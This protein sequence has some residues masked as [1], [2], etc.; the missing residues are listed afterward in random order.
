M[1]D[2]IDGN[3]GR[4]HGVLAVDMR[5]VGKSFGASPILR[6]F[7]LAIERGSFVALLGASGS[8]KST[9]LR[10]LL[11]LEDIDSG[12]V[13]VAPNRTV[14]FQDARLVR[15][16]DVSAN[17]LIGQKRTAAARQVAVRALHE[18]GLSHRLH[19]WPH[20]LSGGEAQR[21]ALARALV[22]EPQLLLLDE[23]FAALDALTRIRMQQLVA[24]LCDRHQPAVLLVTHDVDEALLLADRVVIL[25]EGALALDRP[26]PLGRPRN[27]NAPGFAALRQELLQILGVNDD[28]GAGP[29]APAIRGAAE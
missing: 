13:L 29:Q 19:A 3:G 14:V 7:D 28:V 8:G 6:G 23:P 10:I 17:V 5:G 27:R 15:N 11:G 16:L 4:D 2:A 1:P 9:V 12:S 21:V 20:T 24:E 25:R 18:V 22:R 26:V